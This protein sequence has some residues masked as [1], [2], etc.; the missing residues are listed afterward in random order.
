MKISPARFA[1]AVLA[2]LMLASCGKTTPITSGSPTPGPAY[3]PNVSNEY[4]IPTANSDP[5]SIT[6][7]A[8]ALWFTEENAD[9]IGELPDTQNAKIVEFPI[10]TAA[11]KPISITLGEDGNLWFTESAKSQIGKVSTAGSSFVECRLPTQGGLTPAPYGIAAGND[12]NLWVTDPGTNGIWRVTT[13][14]TAT[15]FALKTANAGPE[16]IAAGPNGALWFVE[17]NVDQIGEISP[18]ATVGTMPSE[19][20]VTAGSGLGTIV[21]GADNA[22]WFTETKT[23]KLGRM[24]ATGVLASETALPGVKSPSG[25]VLGPDGN[26]YIGDPGNSAIAQ[27]VTSTGKVTE[28]ATKTPAAGVGGLSIGPDNEVYFTEPT[29][30]NIGQFRYF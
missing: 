27:Y 17:T 4:S 23:D 19:Y 2:A 28:Y 21:S 6:R 18:Q 9:Q 16:S 7:S 25:L 5:T 13:A 12:G 11:A 29:A 3:V 1:G 8:A 10:P 30:N 24:L 14:C 15:F 22:L 20:P 26:F